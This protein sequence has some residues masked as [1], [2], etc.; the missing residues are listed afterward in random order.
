MVDDADA[1]A[2]AE[3]MASMDVAILGTR[4]LMEDLADRTRLAE[5]VIAF[6]ERLGAVKSQLRD[7]SRT[8]GARS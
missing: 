7:V 6:A 5:E 8:A 1:E 2:D 3:E 4:T